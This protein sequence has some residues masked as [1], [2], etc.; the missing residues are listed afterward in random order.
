[1]GSEPE[2]ARFLFLICW[3]DHEPQREGVKRLCKMLAKL[4]NTL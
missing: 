2:F 1:M 4:I 3:P